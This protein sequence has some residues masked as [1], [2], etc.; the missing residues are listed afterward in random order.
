[1]IKIEPKPPSPLAA[2]PAAGEG[3]LEELAGLHPVDRSPLVAAAATA[4]AA[5]SAAALAGVAK[6]TRNVKSAEVET[7]LSERR[8]AQSYD[9]AELNPQFLL[10]TCR[11]SNNEQL[12]PVPPGRDTAAITIAPSASITAVIARRSATTVA[13]AASSVPTTPLEGSTAAASSS[14]AM[15]M[16]RNAYLHRATTCTDSP[17]LA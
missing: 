6:Q 3:V 13:T 2:A 15:P 16:A 17:S 12:V 9:D 14:T 4:S 10:T 5:A 7:K 11:P 1:T 8:E